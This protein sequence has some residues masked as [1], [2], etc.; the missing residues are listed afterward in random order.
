[1]IDDFRFARPPKII[2]AAGAFGNLGQILSG[3]GKRVLLVTEG[4]F[5]ET[6]GALASLF[7]DFSRSGIEVFH[8]C[9]EGEPSPDWVDETVSEHRDASVAAVVGIGGGSAVDAAK[10]VSAM[11]PQKRSVV[12]FL[13]GVGAGAEHDGRKVPCVAVP[14]TAGTGAEATK[15]AVLSR[16]GPGGFKKSLRHDNFVPDVA[17]V[18]PE[19]ML[20]CPR[21]VTAACGMDAFTQL[22]ESYVSTGAPPMTDALALSGLEACAR[23]LLRVCGEGAEDIGA[24]ADMAYA[25]LLSGITLANA[26]LGVV[27]GLASP[28]GGL[29]EIPHGV[30]CGT[31]VAPATEAT[32]RKLR[33]T[34]SPTCE[35]L[36][37][38]ARVGAILTGSDPEGVD[39]GCDLLVETLQRWTKDLRIPTLADYGIAER[40]LDKI[41]EGAGNKNNPASLD[42]EEIREIC[43]RRL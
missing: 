18:D 29:F 34:G 24:R 39:R 16:I 9:M 37:K 13:E 21:D 4:R 30:V 36:R 26:G 14:T 40:D 11:L 42:E 17:V 41:V 33:E 10:A 6:S 1:M 19:L 15:N 22:L 23:S 32:I 25:A 38:Y 35:A 8:V 12:D 20:S 31:L 28:I 43:L 7:S 27:H 3:F 2:F 5:L